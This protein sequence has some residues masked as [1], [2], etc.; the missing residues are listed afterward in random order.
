MTFAIA[1]TLA[2]V[3]AMV[4]LLAADRAPPDL[5]LF[6]GLALLMVA[7]I[8]QPHHALAGFSNPATATVAV[9]LVVAEAARETG[10]LMAISGLIFGQV[11]R[12][13]VALLRLALPVTALSAFLNNTPIVAMLIPVVHDYARRIQQSPSRFLMALSFAATLGGTCT[14]IG[15]STNL[16]VSGLMVQD[17]QRGLGML[18]LG[19]A[20]LPTAVFGLLYL[21]TLGDRL[22]PRR[23]DPEEG[24]ERARREFL[25][26]VEVLADSPLAGRSVQQAG[27]RHLPGLFLA[28][29]RR[30]GGGVL[31]PV[32]PEDLLARG[33]HLV[34]VG[35]AETVG[36]LRAFPGLQ[37]VGEASLDEALRRN[38]YEVVISHHSSLVGLTVRD[39]EFRRRYDA[40]V[41]AVHRAGAR[42]HAK[43]GDIALRPGD[44]LL[45]T[46]AEGFGRTW[47]GGQDFYLATPAHGAPVP[48]YRQAPV[49]LG[50]LALL[51][52]IP[53]V[54]GAPMLL[55]ALG[56]MLALLFTRSLTPR[57]LRRALDVPILVMVA[58]SLGLS[59]ALEVSGTAR[60]LADHMVSLGADLG[61]LGLL[62]VCYLATATLSAVVTNA[63]AAALVFP[64]AM[65]LAEASGLP[66]RPFAI[67]VAMAAS[68]AFATPIAYQTNL[69]V[70]GPGGYRFLDFARVG[71]PLNA[72]CFAVAMLA[73]PWHWGL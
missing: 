3:I 58:S 34:F 35:Q 40:A 20:G 65:S 10:A 39:A 2:V 38:L 1:I 56:A 19:W 46:A 16:V 5:V 60:W 59:Q 57:G 44:T 36:D 70:Q 67:A 50:I 45:L 18:E 24:L 41:L 13:R 63:A 66:L 73:I 47:R 52:L 8:V 27:L 15:T 17:G 12:P 71:L 37:P 64:V 32:G 14:L 30:A 31:S 51:V 54:T 61:P 72:V 69:M 23:Q 42:I 48:R 7:G 33:D 9:L 4:V 68:A 62:A 53:T 22:V 6:G 28:E 55:V 11:T 43:I 25:A 26:E 29:I 49:A 21:V